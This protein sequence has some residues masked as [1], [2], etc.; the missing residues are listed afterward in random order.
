MNGLKF[1]LFF[2]DNLLQQWIEIESQLRLI[3][4]HVIQASF[5]NWINRLIEKTPPKKSTLC[6]RYFIDFG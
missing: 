6:G 1:Q 5:V 2:N 3:C 4:E